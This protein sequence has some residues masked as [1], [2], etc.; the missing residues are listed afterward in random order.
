MK[1]SPSYNFSPRSWYG[2]SVISL[3]LIIA[4]TFDATA[5]TRYNWRNWIDEQVQISDSLSLKSQITFHLN[6]YLKNDLPFKETWHYTMREGKVVIFQVR[7]VI[8]TIEYTEVYYLNRERLICMEQYE[9]MYYPYYEDDIKRG[10]V[11][12]FEGE[13]LRQCVA[14]GKGNSGLATRDQEFASLRKFYDRYKELK[15]HIW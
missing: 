1:K 7:Y 10:E 9:S 13:V 6:K 4:N 3:L 8:D 2:I 12:F 14:L 5:Q 11:L 15:R